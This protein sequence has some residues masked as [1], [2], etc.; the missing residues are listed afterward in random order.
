MTDQP[1]DK[2]V[3][4]DWKKRAQQEKAQFDAQLGGKKAAA[5][6]G[7]RPPSGA[8]EDLGDEVGAAESIFSSF[9]ET[10]AAQAAMYLGLQPDPMTGARRANPEQAKYL[11]DVLGTLEAKTQGNLT[12]EEERHVKLVVHELRMAFVELTQ[13]GGGKGPRPPGVR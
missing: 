5:P 4:S 11:I 2:K 10:L 1:I 9:V 7:P 13:G 6:S 8:G 12:P 3:D